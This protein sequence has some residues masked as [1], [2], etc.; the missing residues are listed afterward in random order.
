[1]LALCAPA[2][3]AQDLGTLFHTPQ[4]RARLDR[5]RRGEPVEAFAPQG[6]APAAMTGFVQRSDG[7]ATVWLDGRPVTVPAARA[8]RLDPRWVRPGGDDSEGPKVQRLPAR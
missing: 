3:A 5:L 1:V 8:P 7:R 4:E 2:A 6:S